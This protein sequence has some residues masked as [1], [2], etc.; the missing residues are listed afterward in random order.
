MFKHVYT[1]HSSVRPFG[2]ATLI[3]AYDRSGPQLY[4]I[5]PSGVYYVR[6]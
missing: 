2:V 4:M 3:A 1:L 6:S 5:E